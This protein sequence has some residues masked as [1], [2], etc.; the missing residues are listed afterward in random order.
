MRTKEAAMSE[1][2]SK[3]QGSIA[4]LGHEF[5]LNLLFERAKKLS[6]VV[7]VFKQ[8]MKTGNNP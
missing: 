5:K 3:P 7:C 2:Y 4:L 8:P 1:I 6:V